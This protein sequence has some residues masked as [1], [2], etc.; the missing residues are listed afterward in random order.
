MVD[1]RR[2]RGEGIVGNQVRK[3]WRFWRFGGIPV[4]RQEWDIGGV[5]RLDVV[6]ARAALLP[7]I[8]V[9]LPVEVLLSMACNLVWGFGMVLT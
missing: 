8:F 5:H 7:R 9:F 3:R 1:C 2:W 4:A 6:V